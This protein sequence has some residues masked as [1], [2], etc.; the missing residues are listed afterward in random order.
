[1]FTIKCEN[2]TYKYED[3]VEPIIKDLSLDI[4]AHDR[5][6][7]IGSNGKGKSTLIRLIIG[8]LKP[9]QG[10]IIKPK[11]SLRIAYLS[12]ND[13]IEA[14]ISVIDYCLPE[15]IKN[16]KLQIEHLE[17]LLSESQDSKII[18]QYG[19]SLS[20]FQEREAYQIEYK[21]EKILKQLGFQTSIL[22]RNIQTLSGGEKSKLKIAR[23]LLEEPE[24]LI[25]DEASNH[26]DIEMIEWLED[27]LNNFHGAVLF[28]SHDR[29]FID[30][31]ATKIIVMERQSYC[32][33]KS[34]YSD[35]LQQKE[36]EFHLQMTR[37]TERQAKISQLESAAQARRK[38]ASSFQRETG[39]E[40]KSYTFEMVTNPAK[41]MMRQA[42][43]IEARIRNLEEK[44]PIQKPWIEKKR[45]IQF[46]KEPL[47]SQ[48]VFTLKDIC[49]S[50]GD[51]KVFDHFNLMVERQE[52]IHL[53]GKNGSGKSSLLKLLNGIIQA[54]KGEVLFGQHL[55]VRYFEQELD[56]LDPESTI[57]SYLLRFNPDQ[58]YVR[59]VMGCLK[60]ERDQVYQMI[61]TLSAG[62]QVKVA[63]CALLI[64]ESNVL[65]LDEPANHLDIDSRIAL[66]QALLQYP[67]TIIFVSH[68]R[69]FAQTLA[70]RVVDL[71]QSV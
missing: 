6:A 28:V 39:R 61:G 66:E 30:H 45:E 18:E 20:Q 63:L 10:Q 44:D 8:E 59:T 31:L 48:T 60:I 23:M 65:L 11:Q 57:L 36:D 26:L 27:F 16:L 5:V 7:I 43:S 14:D 37:Y 3:S 47:I 71:S 58:T 67:G 24:L 46:I 69:T 51:T 38:W 13:S 54:D 4:N 68:D 35:Y 41:Q 49:L 32:I 52:R 22:E 70:S 53:R 62:E 25:L 17:T 29:S 50:F 55:K 15:D 34:N 21:C 64:Q 33:M 1:M 40:G 56:S 12:Q 2:I 9:N 42:K 19:E